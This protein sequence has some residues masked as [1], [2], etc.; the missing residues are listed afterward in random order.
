MKPGGRFLPFPFVTAATQS[1][2]PSYL[3]SFCAALP[4]SQVI[5]EALRDTAAQTNLVR[6]GLQG[7][8][9]GDTGLEY[10]SGLF[11]VS[12]R[13]AVTWPAVT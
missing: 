3:Y 6:I 5:V 9:F 11:P 2:V 10:M 13:L 4:L 12:A 1:L 7:N 8:C